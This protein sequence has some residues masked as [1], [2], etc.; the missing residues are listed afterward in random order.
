MELFF[1]HPIPH[2]PVLLS[3]CSPPFQD[4]FKDPLFQE[5][6]PRN[7]SPYLD[8]LLPFL[9]TQGTFVF[10]C[11]S[12][13]LPFTKIIYVLILSC[14]IIQ[15]LLGKKNQTTLGISNRGNLIEGVYYVGD[16]RA[17]KTNRFNGAYQRLAIVESHSHAWG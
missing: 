1:S 14:C 7:F 11:V 4:N 16:E 12:S 15:D 6:F 8:I 2:P 17:D 13:S 9:K 3:V 5:A 10:H